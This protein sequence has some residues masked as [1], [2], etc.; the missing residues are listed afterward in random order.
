M[1]YFYIIQHRETGML[2]AGSKTGSDSDPSNFMIHY[3]TSSNFVNSL[4]SAS[5]GVLF[6]IRKLITFTDAKAAYD[7]E[8]KF[9]KCVKAKRNPKFINCHENDLAHYLSEHHAKWLS[10][11]GVENSFQ[12]PFVKEKIRET[13]VKRYGVP[14]PSMSPELLAKKEANNLK[15][16]GVRNTTQ[17]E[18]VQKK[19][20]ETN[21]KKYGVSNPN[22]SS[23][24]RA[25]TK[26]TCQGKF[27]GNAPACSQRYWKE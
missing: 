4:L 12:I 13:N 19:M 17:L 11:H 16:Y 2:Y 23:T 15:K 22:M 9:L 26:T 8:T 6:S 3:T 14:H 25:K 1:F 21:L 20:R 24:V 7:Y 5:P 18:E 10:L 27:G